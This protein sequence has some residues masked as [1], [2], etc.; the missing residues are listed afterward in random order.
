MSGLMPRVVVAV[1]FLTLA[2]MGPVTADAQGHHGRVPPHP[3]G[4][5][6]VRGHGVFIGGYFYD[7]HFG[8]YPW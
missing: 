5:F 2:A 7:P 8:P 4:H 6:A 1:C 3:P